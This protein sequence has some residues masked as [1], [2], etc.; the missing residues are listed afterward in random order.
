MAI[1]NSTIVGQRG[2]L[3]LNPKT[4]MP[5]GQ[6]YGRL[7]ILGERFHTRNDSGAKTTRVVCECSCGRIIVGKA[8]QI[9][10][11][12]VQSCGCFSSELTAASHRTHGFYETN[13]RIFHVWKGVIARCYNPKSVRYKDWGGRGISVCEEWRHNPVA[14]VEWAMS[15]GWKP[16]LEIDRIDNDGNY[17]PENCHFVTAS[18]NSSN[19]RTAFLVTAWGETKNSKTWARDHRAQASYLCI[20]KRIKTGWN[21]EDAISTPSGGKVK[22]S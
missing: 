4:D 20:W 17:C 8:D 21:P 13:N 14:F 16:G 2:I 5:I 18:Q 6:T 9:R 10:I 19:R 7:T 11:G 22:P 1:R 3:I 12:K 15:N